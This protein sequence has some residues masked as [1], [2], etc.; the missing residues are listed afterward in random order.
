MTRVLRPRR[1]NPLWIRVPISS[2]VP[3]RNDR[4]S[5]VLWVTIVNLGLAQVIFGGAWCGC[6]LAG[7]ATGLAIMTKGPIC[8]LQTILPFAVF[9]VWQRLQPTSERDEPFPREETLTGSVKNTFGQVRRRQRVILPAIAGVLLG[10]H[11][12]HDLVRV[13]GIEGSRAKGLWFAEATRICADGRAPHTGWYFYLAGMWLFLPW[14][15]WIV[16]GTLQAGAGRY[17]GRLRLALC[18]L[19]VPLLVMSFS[20]DRFVR[21]MTPMIG[22]G[23]IVAAAG[24]CAA[25]RMRAGATGCKTAA[26]ESAFRNV[27]CAVTYS[28]PAALGVLGLLL[29]GY[30]IAGRLGIGSFRLMNGVAWFA[31]SDVLRIG[32]P[33]AAILGAGAFLATRNQC[34]LIAATAL[35]VFV[36]HVSFTNRLSRSASSQSTLRPIADLIHAQYPDAEL[37]AD[38]PEGRNVISVPADDMS[39]HLNR[40]VRLIAGTGIDRSIRAA[41]GFLDLSICGAGR[42]G[43]AAAGRVDAA[44]QA[45][46]CRKEDR[47][48]SLGC[49]ERPP[50]DAILPTHLC[51]AAHSPIASAR[52]S[53]G[54]RDDEVYSPSPRKRG[55]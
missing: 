52:T 4:R 34:W 31:T 27:G 55:R 15:V 11:C 54:C 46:H 43:N 35:S 18:L 40:T 29:L 12:R 3:G 23:A 25:K 38:R 1:D 49:H 10:A 14:L 44:G 24:L 47:A 39:I 53:R 8:L 16:C 51:D 33:L 32:L 37:F 48:C 5:F 45:E 6:I 36:A 2:P 42:A 41:A 20:R 22:G 7:V 30:L 50:G 26:A 9:V 13:R 17:A 28:D 21:Y 19:V